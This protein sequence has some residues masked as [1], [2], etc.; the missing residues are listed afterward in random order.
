MVKKDFG[1]RLLSLTVVLV[2]VFGMFGTQVTAASLTEDELLYKLNTSIT[3]DGKANAI[4]LLPEDASDLEK[5]AAK[6]LQDHVELVSGAWLP[7]DIQG[8][9]NENDFSASISVES[10]ETKKAGYY[11]FTITLN[12]PTAEAI[13][14]TLSQIGGGNVSVLIR[15]DAGMDGKV[16]LAAGQQAK[17]NCLVKVTES[18]FDAQDVTIAVN[19]GGEQ[20]RA[21]KI[22]LAGAGMVSSFPHIGKT[23]FSNSQNW[24]L[25]SGAKL[26]K[27]TGYDGSKDS[28]KITGKAT[29]THKIPL[30][31]TSGNL[32]RLRFYAKTDAAG[33]TVT[34]KLAD[35]RKDG[36][37]LPMTLN[38]Q[39]AISGTAW[40]VYE[41]FFAANISGDKEYGTSMLSLV[42][43]GNVWIDDLSLVDCGA[44]DNALVSNKNYNY[45]SFEYD[46]N[47]DK[48][49][50]KLLYW[51]KSGYGFT[52]DVVQTQAYTGNKSFLLTVPA[53]IE[54]TLGW[55][56]GTYKDGGTNG[57][58]DNGKPHMAS[59]WAKAEVAGTPLSIR[60]ENRDAKVTHEQ[61][62]LLT[63][64]W[65]R[66][67]FHF[68]PDGLDKLGGLVKF[69]IP[70]DAN[71]TADR[72]VYLDDAYSANTKIAD[73][74]KIPAEAVEEVPQQ[75]ELAAPE[76]KVSTGLKFFLKENE[77]TAGQIGYY[78]YSMVLYNTSDKEMNLVLQQANK[79][80]GDPTILVR[81]ESMLPDKNIDTEAE[82]FDPGA[83]PP[84]AFEPDYSLPDD[85]FDGKVK[86]GAGERVIVSGLVVVTDASSV[87]RFPMVINAMDGEELVAEIPLQVNVVPSV[88]YIGNTTFK[89]DMNWTLDTNSTLDGSVGYEDST[90][91]KITGSAQPAHTAGI[92][93][94]TGSLYRLRFW[95]KA[96]P[97]G[98]TVRAELIDCDSNN[99]PVN[100]SLNLTKTISSDWTEY[101]YYFVANSGQE[102][103]Y[104][105][106]RLTLHCEGNLW[107]DDLSLVDC[108]EPTNKLVYADGRDYTDIEFDVNDRGTANYWTG[109]YSNT[110]K[111][112]G[113]QS[114]EMNSVPGKKGMSM[115]S[116][117]MMK[118]EEE[119]QVP[120]TLSFWA[121]A[122][123]DGTPM[124]FVM[125][126]TDSDTP[127]A[128][129][130]LTDEWTHY[131]FDY[132]PEELDPTGKGF[133][134][135]FN[136][137]AGDS[138][139]TAWVDD[140]LLLPTSY[141]SSISTPN[142]VL[143][144]R[145]PS[146]VAPQEPQF[147]YLSIEIA[148]A[149]AQNTKLREKFEKEI[150]YLETLTGPNGR[151]Y[152]PDGFAVQKRDRTVYIFG[153]EDKGTLNGV[154]DFIEYNADVL[155]YR[156]GRT[157]YKENESI[158]LKKYNYY[159]KSPFTI[160]GW[161]AIGAGN[162]GVR[163]V[164]TNFDTQ[165]SR[166][167]MSTMY[168]PCYPKQTSVIDAKEVLDTMGLDYYLLGHN[169]GSWVLNSP[170]YDP[171][172]KVYWNQDRLTGEYLMGQSHG[173]PDYAQLNMWDPDGKVSDCVADSVVAYLELNKSKGL[174][175]EQ[176]GIGMNDTDKMPQPGYD[177]KPFEYA[178]GKFVQPGDKNYLP[179]VCFTFFNTVAQKLRARGWDVQ[180]NIF[181]Y[182]FL[183]TPPAC[184]IDDNLNILFAPL[185]EDI[186]FPLNMN[187]GDYPGY[188]DSG[189]IGYHEDLEGWDQLTDKVAAYTYYDCFAGK[190]VFDRPIG[191]K[192]QADLKYFAEKGFQGMLPEGAMD[193]GAEDDHWGINAM[194]MWLYSKLL[195]NP[196]ASVDKLVKEYCTK[197]YGSASS[198]MLQYYR[199]QQK[200]WDNNT[201]PGAVTFAY[202]LTGY[203]QNFL[204]GSGLVSIMQ[205]Y[206]NDAWNIANADLEA[207]DRIKEAI[208]PI[209][210]T[211]DS[212]VRNT[213]LVDAEE[214]IGT[215][216]NVG[217]DTIL[218]TFDM[219]N[220]I[221]ANTPVIK[222]FY[223]MG[224]D[225]TPTTYAGIDT[226]LRILWD[227]QYLYL[228]YECFD[229]DIEDIVT[230][231]LMNDTGAWFRTKSD[232]VETF[233]TT[234]PTGELFGYFTN[235]TNLHFRYRKMPSAATATYDPTKINYDTSAKLMEDRW[236]AIQA[237]SFESLGITG[238]VNAETAVYAY[239]YRGYYAEA[240]AS[241]ITLAWNGAGTW[242]SSA[243]RQIKLVKDGDLPAPPPSQPSTQPG[244]PETQPG[245]PE[246]Q[247]SAPAQTQPGATQPSVP[248]TQPSVPATQPGD[249]TEQPG[250]PVGMIIALVAGLVVIVAGGAVAF[251]FY[252]KKQAAASKAEETEKATE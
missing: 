123:E 227:D 74:V 88:A 243:T 5:L 197:V 218:N 250:A 9:G 25:G 124:T 192:M 143:N 198:Q 203:L 249:A 116:I 106:S 41:Y 188:D 226:S 191:K 235:P 15:G 93:M 195:W 78:I 12:N 114:L 166:N 184:E 241:Q 76:K 13:D 248:A 107:I 139:R 175:L 99:E 177:D 144:K 148:T 77:I 169:L 28:L 7:I 47:A 189:N 1:K 146:R 80:E 199:L 190:D 22:S 247:P 6:E 200:A 142:E 110:E 231:K 201:E 134:F 252:R 14:V 32:Y 40:T 187:K 154:Y 133:V 233:I 87:K 136:L 33:A 157:A 210:D 245:T 20:L 174:T 49:V 206:L 63:T 105:L 86:L 73:S 30:G 159:E 147:L 149:D 52:G 115:W 29:V 220:D 238:G 89:S 37:A 224:P 168:I 97:S 230:C 151:N 17:V 79:Q 221:W 34:A 19:K 72:K 118:T 141:P 167:K 182:L 119:I 132:F 54:A 162:V 112:S 43:N 165:Q 18:T 180:I 50:N 65:A 170:S 212:H 246:T 161:N 236:V 11:P 125:D 81:G 3:I 68:T 137:P 205:T 60:F 217:K 229:S 16:S 213:G 121:K 172:N 42:C 109:N 215:Y 214:A 183:N 127:L 179:T 83:L 48:T 193:T 145:M 202:P 62:F 240:K 239:F 84:S 152:S 4:I 66:Y 67:E 223:R 128:T 225:G 158:P 155:W 38:T 194:T 96:D 61:T 196:N 222:N 129:F 35:S 173:L 130:I 138:A 44:M 153:T 163:N 98:G 237:I 131:E 46:P 126:R 94:N 242:Q 104:A 85:A 171:E 101:N 26:D 102:A 140:V 207:G 82:D 39:Q 185:H 45:S 55:G 31:L 111:H 219:T 27:T 150:T 10:M 90:S 178:P 113:N 51:T 244:T 36:S 122:R 103:D 2:M 186:R 181:A 108:G 211:L 24:T 251:I 204:M 71:A 56:I 53:K 232:D 21:F 70:K 8:S 91:L 58:D 75:P 164:D 64:E 228:A 23:T 92:R 156:S 209:R 176:V 117:G 95:A 59:I 120:Y 135:R 100:K 234:N 57:T 216:T 208:R 69:V 160:R